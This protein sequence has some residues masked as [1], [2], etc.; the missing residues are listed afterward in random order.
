METMGSA[1]CLIKRARCLARPWIVNALTVCVLLR[2][3]YLPLCYVDLGGWNFCMEIIDVGLGI[4]RVAF[5]RI[6]GVN[7]A[8]VNL[9]KEDLGI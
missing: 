2:V 7:V 9:L 1:G 5:A 8:N 3:H 4:L 6:M